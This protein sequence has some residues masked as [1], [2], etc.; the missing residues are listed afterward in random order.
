MQPLLE[1]QYVPSWQQVAVPSLASQYSVP[2][3]QQQ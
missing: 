3:P 1:Q 2:P